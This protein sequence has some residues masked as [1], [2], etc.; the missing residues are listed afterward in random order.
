MKSLQARRMSP[1]K[2]SWSAG[3]R[4]SARW[5]NATAARGGMCCLGHWTV[6]FS[7]LPTSVYAL[8]DMHVCANVQ[9]KVGKHDCCEW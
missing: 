7:S 5:A 8:L 3:G 4:L 6:G 1:W 2:R 9:A